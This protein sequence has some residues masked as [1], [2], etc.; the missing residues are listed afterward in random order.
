MFYPFISEMKLDEITDF[1]CLKSQN[2]KGC[3]LKL[4]PQKGEFVQ[5]L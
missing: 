3:S 5:S 2:L 1:L 4:T